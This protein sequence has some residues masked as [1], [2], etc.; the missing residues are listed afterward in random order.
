MVASREDIASTVKEA[1]EKGTE[2]NF[3][4]TFD[5]S[6]AISG[7]DLSNPENRINDEIALPNGTGKSQK[8]AIFAEGELAERAREAGADRVF[9]RDELKELGED[10]SRAKNIAEE[11]SSFLAQADL[12]P[13]VGQELGP[14]LGPRGKMP[15]AIPPTEDPTDKIESSRSTVLVRIRENPA[16]NLPVGNEDMSDEEVAENVEAVLDFITSQLPKGPRQIDS[17]VI[18][19]TMGKPVKIG[20]D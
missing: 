5:L 13:V 9:S 17:V 15:E 14:V 6:V 2:R 18:K 3:T 7:I 16:A 12:M 11:Y 20:G 8:V 4:Q 19:T 1:R 10:K